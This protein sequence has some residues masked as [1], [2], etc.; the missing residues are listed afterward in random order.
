MGKGGK[1]DNELGKEIIVSVVSGQALY[2]TGESDLTGAKLYGTVEDT[3]PFSDLI[4]EDAYS[5]DGG[6]ITFSNTTLLESYLKFK[7][8]IPRV[9]T[10]RQRTFTTL[11][12]ITPENLEAEFQVLADNLAKM[13]ILVE[14]QVLTT[15]EGGAY[16]R[17]PKPKKDHFYIGALNGEGQVELTLVSITDTINGELNIT[18]I[19][20]QIITNV[21]EIIEQVMADSG[22]DLST[23]YKNGLDEGAL[24]DR[25]S[26]AYKMQLEI[27]GIEDDIVDLQN[28]IDA[29][30]GEGAAGA[31]Y[32]EITQVD[33]G[34]DLNKV[35]PIH[36]N[37]TIY[38]LADLSGEAEKPCGWVGIATTTDKFKIYSGGFFDVPSG[39]TLTSGLYYHMS[40][41]TPG[42]FSEIKGTEGK[43]QT[44]FQ[45]VEI[46]GVQQVA[47]EIGTAFNIEKEEES[48]SLL[49]T[50]KGW[51]SPG[52][53][54]WTV[55][56]DC[57][58][59]KVTI[60]G[61]GGSAGN[62]NDGEDSV[63]KVDG[64]EKVRGYGGKHGVFDYNRIDS[65][66][67]SSGT[68]GDIIIPGGGAPGGTSHIYDDGSDH[69]PV[70]GSSSGANG[71]LCIK[72]IAVS[73]GEVINVVVG[74]GGA[75]V[76]TPMG[77]HSQTLYAGAGA[78]GYCLVEY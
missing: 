47:V 12:D 14:G 9:R 21:E 31:T 45:C 23:Y 62:G 24:L 54:A 29:L 13:E 48:L 57:Y 32:K 49:P 63:L 3:T 25:F 76:L 52:T 74:K 70:G 15:E 75:K 37:G 41:D 71:G 44:C 55:P 42:V 19:T 10:A 66:A 59:L 64:E 43:V 50:V 46:A 68:G 72:Y 69:R 34:F 4:P 40:Q 1:M 7:V 33:H 51:T 38:E 61:A 27:L 35:L 73:G 65:P 8:L 5:V 53:Y 39:D 11:G 22:I 28:Q 56:L 30:V 58:Q 6:D 77:E 78:D 20:N 67:H 17:I 36:Y 16:P 60:A 18:Q 2:S 26:N